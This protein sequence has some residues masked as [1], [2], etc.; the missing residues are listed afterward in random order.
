MNIKPQNKED[1]TEV[2]N[3]TANTWFTSTEALN[4]NIQA[5]WGAL[6]ETESLSN[7][8]KKNRKDNK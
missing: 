2:N 8:K 1:I 7:W 5:V 4:T 3:C 6:L